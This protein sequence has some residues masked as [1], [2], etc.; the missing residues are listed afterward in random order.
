MQETTRGCPA[1][2]MNTSTTHVLRHYP[3]PSTHPHTRT[4][5]NSLPLPLPLPLPQQWNQKVKFVN[6][7]P[8]YS[9]ELS[10]SVWN[11]NVM[12]AD[13][14]GRLG[15]K[16]GPRWQLVRKP[17][18]SPLYSTALASSPGNRKKLALPALQA[19]GS[20]AP[21]CS[22]RAVMPALCSPARRDWQRPGGA[23]ARLRLQVPGA[24]GL[25]KGRAGACSGGITRAAACGYRGCR[26]LRSEAG[27]EHAPLQD[28]GRMGVQGGKKFD[29]LQLLRANRLG[30]AP[31]AGQRELPLLLPPPARRR[32]A[33]HW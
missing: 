31:N 11:K 19:A 29:S 20:P 13:Q 3:P 14:G 15:G 25:W 4:R 22:G 1:R 6:I 9:M 24:R 33:C 23:G 7:S 32:C 18:L 16:G 2:S 26:G 10:V 30:C 17:P 28:T 5:H 21:A 12:A 8:Q 27:A